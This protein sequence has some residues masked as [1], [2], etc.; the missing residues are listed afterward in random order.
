MTTHLNDQEQV[1]LI[2]TLWKKY[3]SMIVAL[4]A[5]A[6]LGMVAWHFYARFHHTKV[7]QAAAAYQ[8]LLDELSSDKVAASTVNKQAEYIMQ[9]YHSS[10]YAVL[11]A[12]LLA[13]RDIASGQL[14]QAKTHLQ[15]ALAH[16][17]NV[18]YQAIITLR[19]ARLDIAQ[20]QAKHALTLLTHP[21]K[22]FEASYYVVSGQAYTELKQLTQAKESYEA[23][24]KTLSKDDPYHQ[25]VLTYLSGLPND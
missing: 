2:K 21:P 4:L 6:V 16:T 23:A 25:V 12:M 18:P 10:V 8:V 1:E 5:L 24:L 22:G 7:N 9:E 3:A 14:E 20:A 11:A 15:W 17:N 13:S 19:L